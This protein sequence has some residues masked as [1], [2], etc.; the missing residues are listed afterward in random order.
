MT[1]PIKRN[2]YQGNNKP[3]ENKSILKQFLVGLVCFILALG[4]VLVLS[5][6][7]R[8]D[9]IKQCHQYNQWLDEGYVMFELTD[10]MKA[11][12]VDLGVP[13]AEE[14]QTE[15]KSLESSPVASPEAL[16]VTPESF[17]YNPEHI[18]AVIDQY[19]RSNGADVGLA[20]AVAKCESQFT[21]VAN[22][23]GETYGIGIF[24]FVRSTWNERCAGEI[25]DIYDNIN[26]GTKL[27]ALKEYHHWIPYI[28]NCLAKQGYNFN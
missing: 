15:V 21:N 19:A 10:E 6:G 18:K 20:T 1:F 25:W 16:K 8:R 23:G 11:V 27:L 28:R 7:L 5:E 17:D 12:C 24:M 9:S 26:C 2:V 22:S 14:P 4:F 13:M 3:V